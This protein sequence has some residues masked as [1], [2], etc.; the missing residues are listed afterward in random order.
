MKKFNCN[1]IF[2]NLPLALAYNKVIYDDNNEIKDFIILKTNKSLEEVTGFKKEDVINKKG[3]NILKDIINNPIEFIQIC[4]EVASNGKSKTLEVYSKITGNY[5]AVRIFSDKEDYFATVFSDITERKL[6]EKELKE[7]NERLNNIFNNS[8]DIIYSLSWP[9]LQIKFVSRAVEDIFGYTAEEFKKDSSLLRDITHPDDKY[10]HGQAYQKIEES[11]Y[12]EREFRIITKEGNIKWIHDKGKMIYDVN[13]NPLRTEGIMRDITDRVK[14]RKKL[15]MMNFTVNNSDLFIFRTTPK[16]ITDYVNETVLEKLNY[17]REELIGKNVKKFLKTD[18]YIDREKFWNQ[19]KESRS[20]TYERSYITKD[21]RKFPVEITS[22]YFKYGD[23]EYEFVFAKDITK[24]KIQQEKIK[25]QKNRMEY[26]LEGTDA[27]TWEWNVQTGKTIF[28]EKWARMIGYTLEEISPTTIEIWKK[29]THPDDI[30]KAEKML[31]E[32]FNG[33]KD[34]YKAEIRM[35]H[36][37]GHWVWILDRGKVI[38]WTEDG[39]PLKMFGVHI[40][41]TERKKR[42]ERIK[43]LTFKDYLTELYNRRYFEQ[44][45]ERLDTKRQLPISI[46]M[47]DINGLKIINDSYGH[48]TGDKMLIETGKSLK[49]ELREEDILA[50]HGGDEFTILLP[51][52]S[53]K[54]AE[55]LFSD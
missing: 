44:E 53:Y 16:G 50:R 15:E 43:Y 45:M 22:Q 40:D 5:Y 38:T 49:Q 18:N 4:G 36:K 12:G 47:V 34:Q 11:G 52:T 25:K 26:I 20:L 28:N 2:E 27:G 29:F 17:E 21:G 23:N 7:K 9:E 46:I 30:K 24:R 19:I 37:K 3:F 48:E 51:H 10:I 14:Q 35:R 6:K 8:N 32:H 42:E 33:K 54:E 1:N 31:E 41:I 55:K 39:E 13:N